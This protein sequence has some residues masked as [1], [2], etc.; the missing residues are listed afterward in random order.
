MYHKKL[1]MAI[2]HQLDVLPQ[3]S[4]AHW[5][6]LGYIFTIFMRGYSFGFLFC[7]FHLA[8]FGCN[9]LE[10]L[11]SL[12]TCENLVENWCREIRVNDTENLVFI[13]YI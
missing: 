13:P 1:R 8:G 6:I 7:I 12:M 10:I 4:L 9:D 3:K 2:T 11:K 5:L